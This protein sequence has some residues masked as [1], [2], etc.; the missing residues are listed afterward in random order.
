MKIELLQAWIDGDI[1]VRM[2]VD[3]EHFCDVGR[4]EPEDATVDRDLAFV[5]RIPDLM[6]RAHAAGVAGEPIEVTRREI[7]EEEFFE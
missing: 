3:G 4:S 1:C 2:A 5:L 6:E 7:T